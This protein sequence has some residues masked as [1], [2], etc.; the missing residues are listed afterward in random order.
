MLQLFLEA[1][2]FL[3]QEVVLLHYEVGL[4]LELSEFSSVVSTSVLKL[5]LIEVYLN[6]VVVIEVW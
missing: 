5:K 2:D 1:L 4:V 3:E 6:T